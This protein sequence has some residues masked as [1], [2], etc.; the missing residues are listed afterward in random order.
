MLLPAFFWQDVGNSSK[1][2]FVEQFTSWNRWTERFQGYVLAGILIGMLFIC[3]KYET[4]NSAFTYLWRQYYQKNGSDPYFQ[5]PPSP[6]IL[7]IWLCF[8]IFVCA[9]A[10]SMLILDSVFMKF[11]QRQNERRLSCSTKHAAAA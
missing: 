4:G 8:T 11:K 9:I 6:P 3:E 10:D 5:P 1:E 2:M 7:W